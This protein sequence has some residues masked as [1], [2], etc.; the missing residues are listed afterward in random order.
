MKY[1]RPIQLFQFLRKAKPERVMAVDVGTKFV[2]VAMLNLEMKVSGNLAFY[3]WMISLESPRVM[4][5]LHLK[6]RSWL[7]GTMSR[8]RRLESMMVFSLPIYFI[9]CPSRI[10]GA[11]TLDNPM[12]FLGGLLMFK[13]QKL[14]SSSKSLRKQILSVIWTIHMKIKPSPV[15]L[16]WYGCGLWG[17]RRTRGCR[18]KGRKIRS[19]RLFARGTWI[20]STK[21]SSS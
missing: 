5:L 18:R 6:S 20:S 21:K 14:R 9:I 17:T 1:M 8:A 3:G 7:I 11:W 16:L 4:L 2:G 12:V 13:Q 15:R 10:H 19:P